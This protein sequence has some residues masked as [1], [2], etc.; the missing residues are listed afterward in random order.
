MKNKL[1]KESKTLYLYKMRLM[2][3]ALLVSLFSAN[4]S[5]EIS[6]SSDE[7]EQTQIS[8]TVTDESGMPLAGANII[9]KGTSN[10]T[11]A[12]FDGNYS[13]R[14][15]G[16]ATLVVSY[17]GYVTQEVAVNNQTTVNIIM[18]EDAA[19]L[20]EVVVVGYG[21]QRAKDV[22]GSVVQVTAKDFVKG[23][24]TNAL[25][26]LDGKASGVQISQASSAPG[27]RVD[28]KVR[29]VSSINGGNGVLVVVDGVPNGNV[30]ALGPDDIESI[31]ILKD[32]SASAI[33]GARAANGVVIIT[34][35]R[36]R[37]GALE[38]SYSNYV[39]FQ[40]VANPI[41][42]LNGREYMETMNA[43]DFESDPGNAT[44]PGYTPKY[45]DTEIQAIGEGFDWQDQIFRS[46]LVHNH[47]LSLSGGGEK[48][49]YYASFNHLDSKGTVRQTGE[50]RYNARVNVNVMPTDKL[51][52]KFNLNV[53]RTNT[54]LMPLG[55]ESI[56]GAVASTLTFD[57]TI[58]AQLDENG[59]Y[60]LN[61]FIQVENPEAIM[62][63]F[64]QNRFRTEM[65]G[66]IRIEY[67]LL[68]GLK[69]GL[70]IGTRISNTKYDSYQ[71]RATGLGESAGGSASVRNDDNTYGI[72]E[73]TLA[74]EKEL[75]DHSIKLLGGLTYEKFENRFVNANASQ[76]L[77]DVNGVHYYG[78]ANPER[79]RTQTGKTVRTFRSYLGRLNYAYKD[80]YL[81]TANYRLDGASV[82]SETNKNSVFPSVSLGWQIAS[83]PFMEK[84]DL[85]DVLKLR[86]G[87]GEIGN[88]A[89]NNFETLSTFRIGG[90]MVLGDAFLTGAVPSRI[91]N[92][93][94]VWETTTEVNVGLDFTLLDYRLSGGM[95]Y[96][97]RNTGDQ[98][99]QRPVPRSQG[100]GSF[101]Q[102]FGNVRNSGFEL[103]LSSQN[104]VKDDFTWETDLTF[105]TLKNEVTEV[106]DFVG[107]QVTGGG[108]FAFGG[109]FWVV[110]EGEAMASFYGYQ[111]DGVYSTQAEVDAA[112]AQFPDGTA[113]EGL[114]HPIYADQNGDN[115]IDE[116]D[117]VILGKPFPDFNFGINN[118]FTYKN[119]TL[120]VYVTGV[121]GIDAF[122]NLIAESFYPI[123]PDRN[124]LSKYYLN[125]WTVDN[126]NSP[127]PSMVEPGRYQDGRKA[128]K[129]TVQD[130][131]FVRLKN[132]TLGYDTAFKSLGI[133]SA[134]FYISLENFVTWTDFDGFD[135]DANS[136]S[137]N[138]VQKGTYGDYPLAK[139]VR[140]GARFNL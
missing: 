78:A 22:T 9:E 83:E 41:D 66:N 25:Q 45:T 23:A 63:G 4:A 98:L 60:K 59:R 126:P 57:P 24:N 111:V 74:Y 53:N 114:G 107:G 27:G 56:N 90:N 91:P 6:A 39:A 108:G 12:D 82:F 104:I 129:W 109:D 115:R 13:L 70:H 84:Q 125:R 18:V 52:I 113:R 76:F 42:V 101:R 128:N 11:Q 139:T 72:A 79:F 68:E 130:A 127:Y 46:G 117:R 138:G 123:D 2:T 99:F 17:V 44:D 8:G 103:T 75:G 48:A 40:E 7:F 119:F 131:S 89:I 100:F 122:N 36:G 35:K 69:A 10:G 28:I 55:R 105:A 97:V 50:K 19:A 26:L 38:V 32:A 1:K 102:N 135:V 140:I 33:Y 116:N 86:V 96:Y 34:T 137:G 118:R 133:E 77:S 71:S 51:D 121:Q 49:T 85:F 87:Y 54:D 112:A 47:N 29:G 95:E 21:T 120:D 62:A 15:S 30:D 65:L 94:L 37:K 124:K 110:K 67:E 93:D 106:P 64:N 31:N 20:D 92:T 132:V 16:S 3:I 73:Y 136:S 43:L 14:A 80:K 5:E 61:N 81:V 58:D 88:S 134:N